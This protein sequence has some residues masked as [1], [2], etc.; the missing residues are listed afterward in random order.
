MYIAFQQQLTCSKRMTVLHY[1]LQ[2]EL[3][4]VV[5]SWATVFVTILLL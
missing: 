2:K 5:I 3:G 4:D 1:P